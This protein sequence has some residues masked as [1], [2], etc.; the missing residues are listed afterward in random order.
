MNV[1][2]ILNDNCR[3]KRFDSQQINELGCI[4]HG[5]GMQLLFK[6]F[7]DQAVWAVMMRLLIIMEKV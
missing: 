3:I 7:G 2:N 5:K 4:N 1:Y 6:R